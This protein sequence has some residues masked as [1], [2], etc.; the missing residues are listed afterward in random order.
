MI[1]TLTM[2]PAVDRVVTLANIEL[3]GTNRLKQVHDYACGKGINVSRALKKL[4]VDSVVLGLFAGNEGEMIESALAEE[5]IRLNPTWL[6]TGRTRVNVKVYEE[7]LVRT[8]ELNEQGPEV[9]LQDQ[10]ALWQTLDSLLPQLNYLICSGSLPPGIVPTFYAELLTKCAPFGVKV[11]LDASGEALREGIKNRP[12]MVKPNK[13]EA[14]DLLGMTIGNRESL[15]KA[16]DQLLKM[17][18]PL[19][20]ISLGADGAVFYQQGYPAYFAKA[21]ASQVHSTAGCGDALL[22]GL[23]A[24]ILK[25]ASWEESVCYSVATATATAE[26]SGTEFPDTNHVAC[27]AKDVFME[28]L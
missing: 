5:G 26:L 10:E 3:G 17:E 27:R 18:I 11:C 8:T 6:T 24:S 15:V 20:A 25:G 4:G 2:N 1:A 12:F 7:D 21:A 28:K 14:E 23:L 13:D 22:S 9:S 16:V 19:G